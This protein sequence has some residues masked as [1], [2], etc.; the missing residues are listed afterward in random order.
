MALISLYVKRYRVANERPA[1]IV[2][3]WIQSLKTVRVN[4]ALL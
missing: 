1:L 3:C 4:A 2:P